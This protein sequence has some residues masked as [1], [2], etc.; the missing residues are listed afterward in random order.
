MSQV[1]NCFVCHKFVIMVRVKRTAAAAKQDE[2][3][4]NQNNQEQEPGQIGL[5]RRS[6]LCSNVKLRSSRRPTERYQCH[7]DTNRVR[8]SK[9]K[10]PVKKS[11]TPLKKAAKKHLDKNNN[12]PSTSA[13]TSTKKT[14]NVES[15]SKNVKENEDFKLVSKDLQELIHKASEKGYKLEQLLENLIKI[16]NSDETLLWQ[17]SGKLQKTNAFTYGDIGH[18]KPV[19]DQSMFKLLFG[20]SGVEI[21][22]LKVGAKRLFTLDENMVSEILQK[23]KVV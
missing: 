14:T 6:T 12:E 16:E 13:S 3:S 7:V 10:S 22:R 2:N 19:K 11:S 18:C 21:D 17:S 9:R 23:K 8:K 1:N 20:D 5:K 4:E 15:K